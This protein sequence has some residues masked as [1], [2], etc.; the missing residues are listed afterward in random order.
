MDEA[1]GKRRQKE[2]NWTVVEDAGRG[3]RKWSLRRFRRKL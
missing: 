2:M 1:E 3:W